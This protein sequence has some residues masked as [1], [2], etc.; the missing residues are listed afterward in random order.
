MFWYTRETP[1][2]VPGQVMLDVH[3]Y[4]SD[5][6]PSF[7]GADSQCYRT[8]VSGMPLADNHI[9]RSQRF[10]KVSPAG[11]SDLHQLAALALAVSEDDVRWLI[12]RGA[13]PLVRHHG[14]TVLHHVLVQRR[15]YVGTPGDSFRKTL[16]ARIELWKEFGVSPLLAD[17]NGESPLHAL[18]KRGLSPVAYR[19]SHDVA[20]AEAREIL[21]ALDASRLVLKADR[22]Q[23][24]PFD[25]LMATRS[26]DWAEAFVGAFPGSAVWPALNAELQKSRVPEGVSTRLSALFL[27]SVLE[28]PVEVTAPSRPRL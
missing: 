13:N 16:L 12:D 25:L 6:P 11:W 21:K 24:T 17:R 27:D 28:A 9:K 7:A 20:M 2:S 22:R 4:P 15:A 23:K 18:W 3:Q 10:S 8:L 26:W 1:C 5:L 19:E 14:A